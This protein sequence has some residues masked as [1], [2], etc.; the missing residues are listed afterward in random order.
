ML[1][2]LCVKSLPYLVVSPVACF[3]TISQRW[4]FILELP[5]GHA[6]LPVTRRKLAAFRV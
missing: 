6:D 5:R 3:A 4:A 2:L 1:L